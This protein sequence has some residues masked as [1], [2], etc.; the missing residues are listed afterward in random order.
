MKAGDVISS[1]T[2][3]G[4]GLVDGIFLEAGDIVSVTLGELAPLTITIA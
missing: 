3:A 2:P 1:G 4:I